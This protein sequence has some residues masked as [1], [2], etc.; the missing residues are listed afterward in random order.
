[1]KKLIGMAAIT[2]VL[3]ISIC[4]VA[5]AE[6]GHLKLTDI[7]EAEITVVNEEGEKEI[8]RVDISTVNML[9]GDT[10]V[11]TIVYE[12][13]SDKATENI[14]I[15]NNVPGHMIYIKDS[16]SGEDTEI[17]FSINNGESYHRP[18]ELIKKQ[19]DGTERLALP[20]EYHSI[21]WLVKKSIEPGDKGTVTFKAR[22]K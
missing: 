5:T 9:P 20:E 11:H 21:R 2:A 18:E 8:K 7:S 14:S 17:T 3:L 10:A 6:Q 19:L 13:I 22:V 16:A 12:N 1:M 4:S 15:I